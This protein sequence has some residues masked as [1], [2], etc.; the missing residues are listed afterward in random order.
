LFLFNTNKPFVTIS[1]YQI[2]YAFVLF[3]IYIFGTKLGE[4]L[5]CYITRSQVVVTDARPQL[6]QGDVASVPKPY[7]LT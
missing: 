5:L 6:Q 7:I 2:F 1:T 4:H 3:A